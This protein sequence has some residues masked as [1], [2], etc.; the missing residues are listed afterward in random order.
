MQI[1][2]VVIIMKEEIEFLEYI[3]Q[4]AKMGIESIARLIKSRNKDDNLD[5]IFKEQLN[6]YTKIANSAKG[7]L[8]RRKKDTKELGVMSKIATYMTIKIN[9][10]KENPDKEA[11][12]MVIKGSQMGIEQITKHL[13][14]Y[15]IKTKTVINLANRLIAIEERNLE[16]LVKELKNA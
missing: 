10:S 13:N 4:N 6:D 3:Y 1:I 14:E 11:I 5:K 15:R 12:D 16:R 9:L 2:L 8:K 7:M